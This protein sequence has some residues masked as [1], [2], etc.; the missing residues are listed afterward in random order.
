LR[1]CADHPLDFKGEIMH[2]AQ[3]TR[4]FA[5][6]AAFVAAASSLA[7]LAGCTSA[8][9]EGGD[10]AGASGG[11]GKFVIGFEQPLGGQA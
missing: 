6:G 8:P 2:R 9:A 7:L 10:S 11:D 5:K 1:Y 3:R 4:L